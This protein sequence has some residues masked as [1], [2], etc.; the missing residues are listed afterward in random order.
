MHH[1]GNDIVDLDAPG[2]KNKGLD[3]RFMRKILTGDEMGLVLSRTTPDAFLWALWAAKETAYKA[4]AKGSPEALF[5][6]RKYRVRIQRE[7]S[8][9]PGIVQEGTVVTPWGTAATRTFIRKDHVHCIGIRQTRPDADEKTEDIHYGS[10][11]LAPHAAY[12]RLSPSGRESATAR[13]M[14][15]RHIGRLSGRNENQMEI[16]PAPEIYGSG[17]PA[18]FFNGKPDRIDISLSHDTRFAAYAF[19]L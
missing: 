6:P 3:I 11:R 10:G 8:P 17:A 15:V 1:V 16:R 14:A 9:D 18:L 19:L 13:K 4:I 2:A 12:C 5:S 7:S